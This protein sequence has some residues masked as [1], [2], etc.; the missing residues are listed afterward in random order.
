MKC[1]VGSR[2]LETTIK[3]PGETLKC[4]SKQNDSR[5][6]DDSND[7]DND[8]RAAQVAPPSV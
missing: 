8:D 5:T 3:Q 2:F 1:A 6:K 4:N 7:D